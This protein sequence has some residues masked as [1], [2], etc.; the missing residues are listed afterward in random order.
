MISHASKEAERLGLV[1]APDAPQRPQIVDLRRSQLASLDPLVALQKLTALHIGVTN[2]TSLT[3]LLRC[4]NLKRVRLEGYAP[5]W[6][7]SVRAELETRGVVVDE[8]ASD[9][10]DHCAPFADPILKLA[11]LQAPSEQGVLELPASIPIDQYELVWECGGM[12]VEH[13]VWPQY[14]GETDEFVIRSLAGIDALPNLRAVHLV[15]TQISEDSA[16]LVALR[17]RGVEVDFS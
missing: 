5:A 17:A 15:G 16:E 2:M 1:A 9:Q 7:A 12:T 10:Q 6:H 13:L 4:A 8:A 11:V 3:P 14:D